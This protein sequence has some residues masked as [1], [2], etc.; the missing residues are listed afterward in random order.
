MQASAETTVADVPRSEHATLGMTAPQPNPAT[1]S[2]SFS[3][4]LSESRA[5]QVRIIDVSGRVVRTLARGTMTP[6]THPFEWDLRTEGGHQVPPG[7]YF[8]VAEG[9]SR[10]V[11]RTASR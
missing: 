8:L 2:I 5:L 4:V 11:R 7:V 1:R 10:S 9:Q 3:I 6:G